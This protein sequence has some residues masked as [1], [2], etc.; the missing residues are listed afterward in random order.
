MIF[1]C[2]DLVIAAL[3]LGVKGYLLAHTLAAQMGT[4]KIFLYYS[5]GFFHY[6]LETVKGKQSNYLY[7]KT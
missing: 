3:G 6:F 5:L 1:S 7:T 4:V 2:I